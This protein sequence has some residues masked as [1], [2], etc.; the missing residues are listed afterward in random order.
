MLT[1]SGAG[2]PQ[3]GGDVPFT[4]LVKTDNVGT[5]SDN[6]FTLPWTGTY[7][8]DWGDGNKEDDLVNFQTHT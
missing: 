3:N 2:Q 6:Q 5:S 1:L 4:I 8:V 7:S